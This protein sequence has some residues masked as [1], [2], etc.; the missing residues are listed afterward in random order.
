MIRTRA[1]LIKNLTAKGI[2][3]DELLEAAARTEKPAQNGVGDWIVKGIRFPAGTMFRTWFGDRPYWGTVENGALNI[4]GTVYE[5]PSAA[6]TA[7]YGRPTNG[8]VAFECRRPH[9][10]RWV[11]MDKFRDA[12]QH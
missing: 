3:V 5:S 7:I 9:G 11:R 4:N 12:G 10:K 2:D 1:Q 8:W 6:A